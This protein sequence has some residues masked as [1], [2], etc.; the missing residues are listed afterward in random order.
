MKFEMKTSVLID[1]LSKVIRSTS[2]A[3]EL[4]IL[5]GVY[6]NVTEKSAQFIGSNGEE[7]I[8][9]NLPIEDNIKVIEPGKMVVHKKLLEIVKK[10]KSE[11]V[12]LETDALMLNISFGKSL[13]EVPG[14]DAAEYPT[15]DDVKGDHIF[16][17]SFESFKEMIERTAYCSSEEDSRPIL[18]G[19]NFNLHENQLK[20]VATNAHVLTRKIIEMKADNELTFTAPAISLQ[21]A[22]RVFEREDKIRLSANINQL[23]IESEQITCLIRLL[24]GNFPDT[25]RLIVTDFSTIIKVKTDEFIDV[26]EQIRLIDSGSKSFVANFT[27]EEGVIKLDAK[28]DTGKA[29]IAITPNSVEGGDEAKFS[30]SVL[31]MLNHM[32]AVNSDIVQIGYIDSLKPLGI[33][34]NE[35]DGEYRL[36]LPVRTA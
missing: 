35:I 34:S 7:T 16:D 22:L 32:K 11:Y 24:D 31:Y 14:F 27:M 17:F 30:F 10:A 19:L 33:L 9:I 1:T 8:I 5:Q 18:K 13:F 21:Q 20:V 12:K 25:D 23:I 4:P 15:F 26:L 3:K 2:N 28:S 36:L 29:D 6:I